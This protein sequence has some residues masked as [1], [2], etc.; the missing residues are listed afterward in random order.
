V[1]FHT[2][3]PSLHVSTRTY[4]F[5]SCTV[6][7]PID[8]HDDDMKT[9]QPEQPAGGGLREDTDSELPHTPVLS[10]GHSLSPPP[11]S[12]PGPGDFREHYTAGEVAGDQPVTLYRRKDTTGAR[13]F[14][15]RHQLSDTYQ[16]FGGDL[17]HPEGC[18]PWCCHNK[19]RQAR[20]RSKYIV[21]NMKPHGNSRHVICHN[22]VRRA[23]GA[24]CTSCIE[25]NNDK[26]AARAQQS[27]PMDTTPDAVERPPAHTSSDSLSVSPSSASVASLSSSSA[28]LLNPSHLSAQAITPS[29]QVRPRAPQSSMNRGYHVHPNVL[30][31]SQDSVSVLYDFMAGVLPWNLQCKQRDLDLSQWPSNSYFDPNSNARFDTLWSNPASAMRS[32]PRVK[33]LKT[34]FNKLVKQ[35]KRGDRAPEWVHAASNTPPTGQRFFARAPERL[36]RTMRTAIGGAE[37]LCDVTCVLPEDVRKSID[38]LIAISELAV[39][40]GTLLEYPCDMAELL[41]N[42]PWSVRQWCH[43]ETVNR[44]RRVNAVLRVT[45][46]GGGVYRSTLIYTRRP[47]AYIQGA[48]EDLRAAME[49]DWDTGY[50]G[51]DDGMTRVELDECAVFEFMSDMLHAGPGNPSP[52]WRFVLFM[53]WPLSGADDD[54]DAFIGTFRSWK[55]YYAEKR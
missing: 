48:V 4:P 5:V 37:L 14:C 28:S 18:T 42:H 26:I 43:T 21:V 25:K 47:Y 38:H 10:V 1:S 24:N 55:E 45:D 35:L 8:A 51:T 34:E 33:K 13:N 29:V 27:H 17:L 19:K 2:I 22:K 54:P 41:G 49:H 12:M 16:D 53:S 50:P 9:E 30:R 40:G 32:R 23:A 52:D 31:R 15:T 46:V 36:F 7:V 11:Q 44:I 3:R 39:G 20:P 6:P